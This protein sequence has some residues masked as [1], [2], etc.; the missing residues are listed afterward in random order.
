MTSPQDTRN[1]TGRFY[2]EHGK[3]AFDLA[4]SI[5]LLIALS[6]LLLLISLLIKL[7]SEGPAF[8]TQERMGR[9][10]KGFTL[11][12]FRTM[13]KDAH[14]EGPSV[15]SRGDTRITPLGRTLR[16]YKL[17]ELP[18]LLN[19]VM[20]DM[21]IVGPRPE[22][23]RYVDAFPDEYSSILKV[24]PGITDYAALRY[25]N[26]EEILAGYEDVEQAY[27]KVILPEKITLYK[28]Y[29]REMGVMA[30]VKILFMTLREVSRC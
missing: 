20:G 23:K 27:T 8:F 3:R 2:A 28:K 13:V 24:R 25:R 18:Q 12:K 6:P 4:L 30:D 5:P 11:Y 15:T 10:G 7:G 19:V 21:S 29:I 1:R 17:D 9:G 26:E 14:S 16:R 22:V